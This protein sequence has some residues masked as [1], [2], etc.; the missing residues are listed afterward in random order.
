ML[1][2]HQIRFWYGEMTIRLGGLKALAQLLATWESMLEAV[3]E[4]FMLRVWNLGIVQGHGSVWK[5][6]HHPGSVSKDVGKKYSHASAVGK[7]TPS[8]PFISRKYN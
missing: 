3:V 4:G 6:S 2:N 8:R 5:P 7:S 1:P